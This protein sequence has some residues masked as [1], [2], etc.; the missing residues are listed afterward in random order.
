MEGVAVIAT[1]WSSLV[2]PRLA[3]RVPGRMTRSIQRGQ[4]ARLEQPFMR[5]VDAA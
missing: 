5:A 1:S 4:W 3:E 2:L